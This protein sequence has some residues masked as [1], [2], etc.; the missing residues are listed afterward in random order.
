M[1]AND[2]EIKRDD[3]NPTSYN[4]DADYSI[5]IPGLPDRVNDGLSDACRRV[6]KAG[7]EN[8]CEAMELVNLKTGKSL[9]SELGEYDQVGGEKF[10]KFLEGHSN[11]KFAFVHNHPSTGFLSY[12]DMQT[13]AS[14]EQIQVMV[15]TSNDGLK[16]IAYGD[17]KDF[18]LFDVIYKDEIANIRKRIKDGTLE[19][20]NY[21]NE[22]Q[23]SIVS[24]AI[25]DY[26]NLGFWEVDGRA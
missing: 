19:M 22:F 20:A 14:T 11:D 3:G 10:W 8:Q 24:N 15:S 12:V 9:Y 7:T 2:F 17:T 23:K 18:R 6:A 16:R 1:V 21:R 13:L 5:N 4:P 25:R 26:A